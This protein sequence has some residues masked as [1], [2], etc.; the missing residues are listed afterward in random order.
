MG[1]NKNRSMSD[2]EA[3]ATVGDTGL[4]Q[5]EM[6]TCLTSWAVILIFFSVFDVTE[7]W[8]F[9]ATTTFIAY[10]LDKMPLV[11]S[12]APLAGALYFMFIKRAAITGTLLSGLKKV[13]RRR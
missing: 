4:T 3:V 10:L 8:W 13:L 6:G 7:T 1:T 11:I 12:V 9:A 2:S 5:K